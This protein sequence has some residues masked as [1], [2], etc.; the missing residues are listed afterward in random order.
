MVTE[1]GTIRWAWLWGACYVVLI[2]VVVWSLYG[3]RRWALAEMA[4]P[5]SSGDWLTWRSDVEQQQQHA[6]PVWR[7]VPESVEP[8]A[9]VLMRDYFGVC[10]TGA[11]LFT[12]VLYGVIAWF[13]MGALSTISPPAIPRKSMKLARREPRPPG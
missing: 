10:M 4:T 12:T 8:P 6:G 5:K 2:G 9:I 3:A 13:V 11:L 1:R 7:R